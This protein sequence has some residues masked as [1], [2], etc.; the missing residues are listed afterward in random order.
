M[1][2]ERQVCW[3]ST[4]KDGARRVAHYMVRDGIDARAERRW[5][6][7]VPEDQLER[8]RDHIVLRIECDCLGHS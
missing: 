4:H 7:T 5:V 2:D 1:A 6:V 8:A 3:I